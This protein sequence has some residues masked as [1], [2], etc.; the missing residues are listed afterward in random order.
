[1]PDGRSPGAARTDVRAARLPSRRRSARIAHEK[2]SGSRFRRNRGERSFFSIALCHKGP[3]NELT[4]LQNSCPSSGADCPSESSHDSN[5]FS[6][7]F[8][9]PFSQITM[10]R[11]EAIYGSSAGPMMPVGRAR[12]SRRHLQSVEERI[13]S[14]QDWLFL[15]CV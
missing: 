8:C 7:K 10:L 14:K 3:G 12:R 5:R 9:L 13:H 6:S 11:F 15:L 1:M 2:T 4:D